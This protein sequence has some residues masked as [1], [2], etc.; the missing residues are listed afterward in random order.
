M[1]SSGIIFLRKISILIFLL[2]SLSAF[3]SEECKII[4]FP[5]PPFTHSI[6][7][8][9]L[10][11]KTLKMLKNK[12][13]K[14]VGDLV[15]RTVKELLDALDSDEISFFETAEAMRK[16]KLQFDMEVYWPSD[17]KKKENLVKKLKS[18]PILRT[19]KAEIVNLNLLGFSL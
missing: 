5:R 19:K 14:Y 10:S 16:M 7:S 1:F 11:P 12:D 8:L 13:I 3:S 17:P 4:F 18:R 15:T 6:E 2:N 9:G